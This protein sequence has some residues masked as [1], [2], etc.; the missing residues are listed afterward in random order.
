MRKFVFMLLMLWGIPSLANAQSAQPAVAIPV[1]V[2]AAERKSVTKSQD[3]VGRVEAVERVEVKARITGYLDKVTFKEGDLIK[4]GTPLYSIEKGL[5]EAAVGQAE[6]ALEKD[7]AAKTLSEIQLQRAEELFAK[8]S[9][10]QVA[11]DQALAADE[12][13]RGSLLIDEAN[14]QTARINLGYTEIVSPI[15]G[16]VGRTSITKGNVVSPQT[17]P[18]TVIVSQDPM[19]VTFP[20]SQREFLR[21]QQSGKNVDVTGFK[22]SLLF[23][24][25]SPY[26]HAGKINFIDVTV[27]RSTD[28][29][30]AR[31][32]FP[33]PDF[34]LIDGQLVRVGLEGGAP[35]EKIVVPQA[36]LI[37][38]QEGVYVFV[39]SDGKAAVRRIKPGAAVG[40]GVVAEQ[41]L[42]AGEQVI[43]EG[44][45]GLRPG[46]AVRPTLLPPTP[47]RS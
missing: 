33:N 6:G 46:V 47:D 13:A 23:A 32:S 18:L 15:A 26:K 24:D 39:A 45:Q 30:L 27:D 42:T 40:S 4:E 8:G 16:K 37:S 44:I 20:V 36:A 17:G 19:Y 38:D 11:R 1:G 31:A 34:A 41:G 21:A 25:G 7:K 35:E 9:G 3:F 2:V 14:L 28:T 29:V 22:V 5:F 12:T 43:V 10:T